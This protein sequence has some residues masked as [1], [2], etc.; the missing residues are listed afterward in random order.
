MR[1][2]APELATI[3]AITGS[4][5]ASPTHE[6]VALDNG[7]ILIVEDNPVNR[8]VIG[9]LLKKQGIRF[10]VAENGQE[11][12]TLITNGSCPVLV[13]MDC[14]MPVMDGFSAT[15]TIR[16]WELENNKPR[17]P[18]IAL[19]AGAFEED[20]E[21]CNAAGMDDFLA[22]PLRFQDL[23]TILKKWIGATKDNNVFR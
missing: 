2:S 11:A 22:K 16:R 4:T 10:E 6:S 23:E 9:G 12:V 17:L 21:K 8:M 13:L 20:R 19:T 15:E 5:N 18:I 7:F 3:T 14:Q 1:R